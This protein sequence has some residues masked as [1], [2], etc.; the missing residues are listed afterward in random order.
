V[1]ALFDSN[2]LIDYLNGFNQAKKELALY[3]SR[4][5]SVITW[6]EVMSGCDESAEI[7]TRAWLSTFI[8]IQLDHAIADRAAKMRRSSSVKKVRLPDA[9]I[10]ASAIE[11]GFILVT[12]NSKD[13]DAKSP[14]IR[15]PYFLK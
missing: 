2:I 10:L 8:L 13:F 12:R 9:I 1:R 3:E 11:N 7:T 5:I 6:I 14:A 15:I 4:A